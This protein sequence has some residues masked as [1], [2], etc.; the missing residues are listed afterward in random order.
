MFKR[1]IWVLDV[2]ILLGIYA[3]SYGRSIEVKEYY[4]VSPWYVKVILILVAIFSIYISF[5]KPK[6]KTKSFYVDNGAQSF[7]KQKGKDDIKKPLL[8]Y[9]TDE[10]DRRG[11]NQ[12][13]WKKIGI[14]FNSL[15]KFFKPV[16]ILFFGFVLMV[17]F[18]W[19]VLIIFKQ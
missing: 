2:L 13:V 11:R 3:L 6:G 10:I 17:V 18:V 15:F 5:K 4:I 9:I 19:L 14:V 12:G 7:K 8:V 16:F 1:I